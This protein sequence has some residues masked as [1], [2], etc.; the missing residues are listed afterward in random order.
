MGPAASGGADRGSAPTIAGIG[1]WSFPM[2]APLLI[3]QSSHWEPILIQHDLGVSEGISKRG[4]ALRFQVAVTLR[5]TRSPRAHSS[6]NPS[7]LSRT[8][9]P[10]PPAPLFCWDQ[11]LWL[12]GGSLLGWA[13]ALPRPAPSTPMTAH[14][15]S[16]WR[17]LRPETSASS[18]SHLRGGHPWRRSGLLCSPWRPRCGQKSFHPEQSPRR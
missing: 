9:R 17:H 16:T 6:A 13:V 8:L 11:L 7:K 18:L 5:G 3:H 12:P 10:A 15:M 1:T 14:S 2:S 4:R